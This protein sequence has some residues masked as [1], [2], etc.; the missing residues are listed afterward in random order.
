[1]RGARL[2][3]AQEIEKNQRWAEAKINMLT[4]GDL[5]SA[6]FMRQDFFEFMPTFKI[7]IAGNNKPALTGVN[8]A[9]RR[10]F[11]LVPFVVTIVRVD[12]RL[13]DKLRPEL[14]G[15]LLWAIDGC[16]AWQRIGLAPPAAVEDATEQYL[17]EE[18]TLGRWLAEACIL[19]DPQCFTLVA[20][21]FAV[22]CWWAQQSGEKYGSEK[23]FSRALI[24]KGF[25]HGH[26]TQTRKA[27]FFGL[28]LLISP[29]GILLSP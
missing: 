16:L 15:I 6:R 23:E 29:E 27:G 26:H 21:L 14:P 17:G 13:T 1:M 3:T 25:K 7:I 22:W 24:A 4:G 18:D 5:I 11:Q 2:V 9:A 8:Q 12:T 10:R 19:D 20:N 28:K